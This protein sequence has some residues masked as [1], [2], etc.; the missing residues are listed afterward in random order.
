M[1]IVQI[2]VAEMIASGVFTVFL[3]FLLLAIV[4]GAYFLPTFI[5]GRK[6][7]V[8]SIFLL[9]LFL[10]WTVA[11]WILALILAIK[12]SRLHPQAHKEGPE[13]DSST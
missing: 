6:K 1:V 9:N 10:G 11:G 12:P 4:V 3:G 13:S 7:N 2:N 5:G 8:F